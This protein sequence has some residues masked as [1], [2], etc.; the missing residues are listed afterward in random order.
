M[1]VQ[2]Q[3]KVCVC[4]ADIIKQKGEFGQMVSWCL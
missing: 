1:N 4:N 2:L 3:N